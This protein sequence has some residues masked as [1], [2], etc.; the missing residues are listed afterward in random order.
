VS[1]Q[2]KTTGRHRGRSIAALLLVGF[3]VVTTAVIWRRGYG[4]ARAVE[5]RTLAR[6]RDQLRAER[7]SL[8]RHIADL[9]GRAQL[10]GLAERQ[11]DMHVPAD[12]QVIVLPAP[13]TPQTGGGPR[14]A[15]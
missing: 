10:G 2:R 8:E 6:H 5:L 13:G 4:I 14:A 11:L 1:A 7:T 12:S 3:V 9:T 15:H